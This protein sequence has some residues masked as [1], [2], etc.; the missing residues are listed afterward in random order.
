MIQFNPL[1]LVSATTKMIFTET[2]KAT[3][4]RKKTQFEKEA[5]AQLWRARA[6]ACLNV[7]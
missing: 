2:K 7:K 5:G 6:L 3:V 4:A 1:Y